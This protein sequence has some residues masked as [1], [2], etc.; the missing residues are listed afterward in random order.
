MLCHYWELQTQEWAG[1]SLPDGA[2][3]MKPI[4]RFNLVTLY[5]MWVRGVIWIYLLNVLRLPLCTLTTHSWLNWVD[6]DE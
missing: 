3:E 5:D 2:W 6:E 1:L 4:Q